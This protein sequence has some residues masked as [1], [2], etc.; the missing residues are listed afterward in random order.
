MLLL[1]VHI[2]VAIGCAFSFSKIFVICNDLMAQPLLLA[3]TTK[4]KLDIVLI[5]FH[6]LALQEYWDQMESRIPLKYHLSRC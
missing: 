2:S 6:I 5:Y 3:S 4:D 1:D